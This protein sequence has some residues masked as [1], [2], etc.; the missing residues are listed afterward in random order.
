MR[1]TTELLNV[2]EQFAGGTPEMF[3]D[4]SYLI[5]TPLSPTEYNLKLMSEEEM[6]TEYTNDSSLHVLN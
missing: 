4:N 3:E 5:L 6:L 2:V 1:L